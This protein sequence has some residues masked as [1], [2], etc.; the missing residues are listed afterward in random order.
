MK[1]S[2]LR[3]FGLFLFIFLFSGGFLQ[4]A[5]AAPECTEGA[6]CDGENFLPASEICDVQTQESCFW[7]T[8]CGQ[9]HGFK[10]FTQYCSGDS[11]GCDGRTKE[12]GPFVSPGGDCQPWQVCSLD[13][14]CRAQG[15]CLAPPEI[16]S[17]QNSEENISL[18]LVSR[19]NPVSGANSYRYQIP[20]VLE[21]S[22]QNTEIR[23][24]EEGTCLL[25]SN[26]N[27]GFSVQACI[28]SDGTDCGPSAQV[29]FKTSFSP[30][31]VSPKNNADNVSL[32]VALD[33]CDVAGVKAY[34]LKISLD[35]NCHPYL[36]DDQG[37]CDFF[38]IPIEQRP[39]ES[40]S[41]LHS[42]F[43]SADFF[44]KDNRYDWEMASCYDEDAENCVG[45]GTK[46]G[47]FTGPGEPL[48]APILKTPFYNPSQP[49]P[50]INQLD[51]LTW[52][53]STGTL[54][55]LITVKK[56]EA[57]EATA[58]SYTENLSL[59]EI[60]ELWDQ[61][62]DFNSVFSWQVKPCW[63][64]EARNCEEALSEKWQFKTTGAVPILSSPANNAQAKIPVNLGWQSAPGATAYFYEIAGK[65]G[66]TTGSLI[67]INYP[68]VL[69]AGSYSWRVKTCADLDGIACGSWSEMRNF[70]TFSLSPPT[71][72]Q[73]G[74]GFLPSSL[75]WTPDPGANFYQYKVTYAVKATDE[76]LPSCLPKE[77]QQIIPENPS[78]SPPI[79]SDSGFPFN[80]VCLGEYQWRVR[81]CLD[82][83]C[84]FATDW[85]SSPIWSFTGLTPASI[86]SGLVPCGRT[87]AKDN[88]D[89]PYNEREPC[90]IKH[91]GFLLQNIID[92]LLWRLGLIVLLIL[93]IL[94][95]VT[96]YFSLG[97]PGTLD[98]IKAIWKSFGLGYGIMLISWILVNLIL[99]VA[100]FQIEFFGRWFEL[101]F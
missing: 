32:P 49:L 74:T 57:I 1:F 54:S 55:Y 44:T 24:D 40:T 84:G 6:C 34:I 11:A 12:E 83:N 22:T 26:E 78:Q 93:S 31:S 96:A 66:T 28:N 99:S 19:W 60:A 10:T 67:S 38:P 58:K 23:I 81:S 21:N 45:Y 4:S 16:V 65:N 9:D 75:R 47:F 71:N 48:S 53:G 61:P 30:Q 87:G 39:G 56:S 68:D 5:K 41:T 98:R 82:N 8:G 25:K 2:A 36:V 3:L 13:Q 35:G 27:Y 50:A 100:G 73:P 14:L 97:G 69:P 59:K 33:W 62:E 95:A 88:P 101:P 37:N 64:K 79:T 20:G 76:N 17:P 90:Q 51:F 80:E 86:A 42:D 15:S 7:G 89:T 91:L 63:D 70:G 72:P 52:E 92:F 46:F 94:S 29:N 77:G 18:P 85:T 43:T